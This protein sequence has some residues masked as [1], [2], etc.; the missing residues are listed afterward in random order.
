[1]K[2]GNKGTRK[3]K[4]KEGEGGKVH[5]LEEEFECV[6]ETNKTCLR[7]CERGRGRSVSI[8]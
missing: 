3:E 6:P 5:A 1:M 7:A 2:E 4:E 8:E